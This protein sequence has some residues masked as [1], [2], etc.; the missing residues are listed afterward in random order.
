MFIALYRCNTLWYVLTY[1]LNRHVHTNSLAAFF[2]NRLSSYL[3]PIWTTVT[4]LSFALSGTVTE[5]ITACSFVFSKH[6][7]DIGDRVT[8]E[9]KDLIVHKICLQY[10]IF[11]RVSDGAVEQI[12]HKKICDS[13]IANMSRSK[14]LSVKETA[15]IPDN[16]ISICKATLD[17]YQVTLKQFIKEK[18]VRFRYLSADDIQISVQSSKDDGRKLVAIIKLKE[19]LVRREDILNGVRIEIRSKL[20]DIVKAAAESD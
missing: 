18:A 5:F 19:L 2:T 7:Y 17:R 12:A 9:D 10:T 15:A 14:D 13:W 4:G 20:E 16:S 3:T 1:I 8:I 11:R 6:P